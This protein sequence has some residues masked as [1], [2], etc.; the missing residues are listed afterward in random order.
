[1]E[2]TREELI[3]FFDFKCLFRLSTLNPGKLK[4]AFDAGDKFEIRFGPTLLNSD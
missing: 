2:F 4:Q 1:M 3:Y